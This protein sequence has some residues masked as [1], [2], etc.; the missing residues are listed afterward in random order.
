MPVLC[1]Q[2]CK[3]KGPNWPLFVFLGFISDCSAGF[4]QLVRSGGNSKSCLHIYIEDLAVQRINGTIIAGLSLSFDSPV[5]MIFAPVTNLLLYALGELFQLNCIS[6][7][8]D[9]NKGTDHVHA[10]P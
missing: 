4:P 2:S 8:T 6:K 9:N 10:Q 3:R 5:A 1:L 7:F